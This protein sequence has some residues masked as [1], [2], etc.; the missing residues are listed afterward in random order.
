MN[1]PLSR[2]MK[3]MYHSVR[4]CDVVAHPEAQGLCSTRVLTVKLFEI[5]HD[6]INGD[7]VRANNTHDRQGQSTTRSCR[8]LHCCSV[9]SEKG[10]ENWILVDLPLLLLLWELDLS[11]VEF[12]GGDD[13]ETLCQF[14]SLITKTE[15]ERN[16]VLLYS[17]GVDSDDSCALEPQIKISFWEFF[18][19]SHCYYYTN[20]NEFWTRR[21]IWYENIYWFLFLFLFTHSSSSVSKKKIEFSVKLFSKIDRSSKPSLVDFVLC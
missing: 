8:R 4:N 14:Q 16:S 21:K 6:P 9:W 20:C 10:E 3:G 1:I 12:V 5:V 13:V 11:S 17:V 19:K 18:A 2:L 15:D 7:L